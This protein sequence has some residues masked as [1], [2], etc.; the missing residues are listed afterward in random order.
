MVQNDDGQR[1]VVEPCVG[2]ISANIL[3]A[4]KSSG[5]GKKT[6]SN[7]ALGLVLLSVSL[8][9]HQSHTYCCSI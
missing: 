6:L 2:R 8:S 9:V 3:L 1:V 4:P 7:G 5:A